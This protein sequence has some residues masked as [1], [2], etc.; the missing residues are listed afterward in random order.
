[1]RTNHNYGPLVII[2]G[3]EDK[4]EECKILRVFVRLAGGDHARIVV[5]TVAS[6][7]PVEVGARYVKVFK[8][9]G[10]KEAQPLDISSR[11]DASAP[12][13]LEQIEKATG[14]FFTGGDQDR[15]VKLL[16]GTKMDALLHER[17]REG[18]VLGGTSAGASM[19]SSTMIVGDVLMEA[20][21]RMGMVELRPGM[22][23]IPGVVIDQ[24]F[25]ERGR[26]KRLLSAVAQYPHHLGVGINEDTAIVVKNNEFD[27]IGEG[28]VT[29]IDMGDLTHTNLPEIKKNEILA[30][31]GVKLHV[32][33]VGYRFDLRNRTPIIEEDAAK[34]ERAPKPDRTK[35]QIK[36]KR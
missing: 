30:L 35:K 15:I 6:R 25:E 33:P 36:S 24:H 20:T 17:H 11:E 22:E 31:C 1:M 13:A 8:R 10:A 16:G 29:V 19:M 5:M 26:L 32:L 9:L 34:E 27:V 12:T 23:F 7:R 18:L 28:T 3:A 21:P 2:G 4:T 14:V